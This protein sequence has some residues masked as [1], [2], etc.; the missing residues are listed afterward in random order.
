MSAS[1]AYAREIEKERARAAQ[2]EAR[3][4]ELEAALVASERTVPSC[5]R[6]TR[7]A[8]TILRV[9][10]AR[11]VATK[12]AIFAALYGGL[13]D[14]PGYKIVDVYIC[15]LRAV[16]RPHGIGI[17]TILGRGWAISPEGL[18]KLRALVESETRARDAALAG[19]A[20]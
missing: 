16:L 12:E 11:P 7:T 6:L 9:L 15:K 1:D 19:W 20:A 8:D 10:I 13:D 2:L 3:C 4:L 18:R 14:E 5:L 17:E